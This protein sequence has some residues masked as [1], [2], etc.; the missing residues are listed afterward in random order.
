MSLR[1]GARGGFD[2][3]ASART[4]GPSD[5]GEAPPPPVAPA[6][7]RPVIRAPGV[8]MG[9]FIALPLPV[10]EAQPAPGPSLVSVTPV[11]SAGVSAAGSGAAGGDAATTAF[12]GRDEV[13]FGATRSPVRA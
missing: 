6:R 7:L 2:R 11:K 1:T 10:A 3:S 9:P 5:F 4:G 12:A 8:P 13:R